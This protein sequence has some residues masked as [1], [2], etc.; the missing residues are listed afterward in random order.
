[1][2]TPKMKF[3]LSGHVSRV[4]RRQRGFAHNVDEEVDRAGRLISVSLATSA[5]PF[6]VEDAA[7]QA[8][9]KA[10]QRD[11]KRIYATPSQVYAEIKSNAGKNV[12][13]AFYKL[14]QAGGTGYQIIKRHA[15]SYK[16]GR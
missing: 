1:M 2:M 14:L 10:V 4:R 7:L 6:G 5:Q 12:A 3:D 13:D 8:G 9:A 16:I 15:P 11:I